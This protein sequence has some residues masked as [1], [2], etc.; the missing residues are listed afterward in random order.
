MDLASH[1]GNYGGTLFW[2]VFYGVPR[3][4]V[5]NRGDT[6]GSCV[7]SLPYY[8]FAAKLA[9]SLRF[10]QRQVYGVEHGDL[11]VLSVRWLLPYI[12]FGIG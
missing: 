6:A 10:K 3:I 9:F 2:E 11:A 1:T 8:V 12:E 5:C 7:W 4:E